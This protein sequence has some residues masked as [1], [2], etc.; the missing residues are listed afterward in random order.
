MTTDGRADFWLT[1]LHVWAGKLRSIA[2]FWDSPLLDWRDRQAFPVEWGNIIIGRLE[3]VEG[4]DCQRK[5]RPS[6]RVELR[7]VADELHELL[8]TMRRL[9]LRQPDP[10]ALERARRIEAARTP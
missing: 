9:K 7:A 6:A 5:L 10:E 8:P 4:L 1:S 3:K 2:D